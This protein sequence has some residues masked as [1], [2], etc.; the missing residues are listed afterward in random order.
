LQIHGLFIIIEEEITGGTLEEEGIFGLSVELMAATTNFTVGIAS[1]VTSATLD[2]VSNACNVGRLLT[3]SPASKELSIAKSVRRE[4]EALVLEKIAAALP[5][6][7]L[8][9]AFPVLIS[10]SVV[11]RM[12]APNY[13]HEVNGLLLQ[14]SSSSDH[15]FYTAKSHDSIDSEAS[16]D[17]DVPGVGSD[18][19]E[20]SKSSIPSDSSLRTDRTSSLST[21][22]ESSGA[23]SD[24]SEDDG[25]DEF[26][27]FVEQDDAQLDNQTTPVKNELEGEIQEETCSEIF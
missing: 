15:T 12:L 19:V 2:A 24:D 7:I 23:T 20:D 18:A 5:H 9:V 4:M 14:A 25:Y 17:Q 21:L 26:L 13:L 1:A 11:I 22:S 16:W 8:N 6:M 3:G 10:P 27:K